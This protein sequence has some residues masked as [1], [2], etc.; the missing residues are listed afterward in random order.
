MKKLEIPYKE[1]QNEILTIIYN[2]MFEP[3]NLLNFCEKMSQKIY[4][5][6]VTYEDV[7]KLQSTTIVKHMIHVGLLSACRAKEE[8]YSQKEIYSILFAGCIHDIG[9]FYIPSEI[10]T[11]PKKLTI[12]EKEIIDLHAVLGYEILLE[13]DFVSQNVLEMVLFH[14]NPKQS[15]LKLT[16][17]LS[18]EDIK[19]A[20]Q[21]NSYRSYEKY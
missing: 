2:H 8:N 6:E 9:K 3:V 1:L 4:V 7:K 18:E 13:N 11:K 16:K 14:H 10:L 21:S 19:D 17:I 15:E 20:I 5:N 12:K